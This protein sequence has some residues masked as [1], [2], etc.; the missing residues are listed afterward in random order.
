P[1]IRL[2]DLMRELSVQSASGGGQVL[3]HAMFSFQDVRQR[4]LEWG[5]VRH[6]RVELADPGATQDLGL[7]LVENDGGLAGAVV[8][9][10]ETLYAAPA[11]VLWERY[12]DMLQSLVADPAQSLGALT[13]FDDG[14]PR[15]MGRE[16]DIA[17]TAR[18]LPPKDEAADSG[19]APAGAVDLPA[20][21]PAPSAHAGAG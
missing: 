3:Y 13:R 5:N 4:V 17:A 9:N 19:I 15:L 1:D 6:S 8:Y 10:S 2:E 14:L 11:A 20:A 18:V 7:W 12:G 21:A 16:H